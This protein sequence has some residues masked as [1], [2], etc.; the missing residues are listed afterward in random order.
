MHSN[1]SV[2][3]VRTDIAK[4]V[5]PLV[6]S[7][8]ANYYYYCVSTVLLLDESVHSLKALASLTRFSSIQ[9]SNRK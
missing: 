5:P 9:S 7:T 4:L 1:N 3:V 2:A 6:P 8:S